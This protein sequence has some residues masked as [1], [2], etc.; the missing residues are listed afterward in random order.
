MLARR[1]IAVAAVALIGATGCGGSASS[2]SEQ[3]TL[4]AHAMG[5][6]SFLPSDLAAC[7]KQEVARLP[8]AELRE[9]GQTAS[10]PSLA[11][12]QLEARLASTCVREG[13]GVTE[14]RALAMLR[15]GPAIPKNLPPSFRSC[16]ERKAPQALTPDAL[17][18]LL[19]AYLIGGQAGLEARGQQLGRG[20]AAQCLHD[21]AALAG[22]REV[23]LGPLRR[24]TK[25]AGVASGLLKCVVRRAQQ[26]PASQ[27]EQLVRHPL[28]APGLALGIARSLAR[29]CVVSG[30]LP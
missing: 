4:V 18:Q 15:L 22:L 9:L 12:R 23:V 11:A 30:L 3:S 24:L 21:P 1:T 8:M 14:L 25:K 16:I 6:L 29:D 5:W 20:L 2:S 17:A 26:I 27:L 10:A 7:V 28:H 19:S 13:K